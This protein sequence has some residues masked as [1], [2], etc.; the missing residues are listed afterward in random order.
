MD[1]TDQST[2][3]GDETAFPPASISKN[4]IQVRLSRRFL[5]HLH[6]HR[7]NSDAGGAGAV[8]FCEIQTGAA[9]AATNVQ[10]ARA[11]VYVCEL[12]EM[13]DKLDL[14]YFFRSIATHPVAM[15]YV[16]APQGG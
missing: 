6:L 15:V 7:R 1:S 11:G 13:I 8:L 16:L 5:G 3:K 12:R 10:N 9:K 14:R 4:W 2:S